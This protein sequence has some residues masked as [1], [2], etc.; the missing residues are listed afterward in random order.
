MGVAVPICTGIK[1]QIFASPTW[2]DLLDSALPFPM[3]NMKSHDRF[4]TF[5][6]TLL[7]P[8][9]ETEAEGS[10]RTGQLGMGRS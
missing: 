10:M 2:A 8:E 5:T 7:G 3:K 4:R 6:T 9:G 1:L